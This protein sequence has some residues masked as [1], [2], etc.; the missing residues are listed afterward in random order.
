MTNNFYHFQFLMTAF[1][2]TEYIYNP[3]AYLV[4]QSVQ[5]K[6][7]DV[8]R[9]EFP[10]EIEDDMRYMWT[11]IVKCGLRIATTRYRPR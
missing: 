5:E 2:P 6:G 7:K 4:L 9:P 8:R 3:S 11:K 10:S 1:L